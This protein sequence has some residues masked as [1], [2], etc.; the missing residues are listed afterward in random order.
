MVADG[1]LGVFAEMRASFFGVEA[2]K[3]VFQGSLASYMVV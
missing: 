3:I 1:I 2:S